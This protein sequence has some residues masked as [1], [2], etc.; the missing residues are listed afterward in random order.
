[1]PSSDTPPAVTPSA[2]HRYRKLSLKYH[3]DKDDS[4]DAAVIFAR[5]AKAYDVLS[6]S[7]LKATS[8][9]HGEQGLKHGAPDGRGGTK[10]GHYAFEVSPVSV[11][12]TFHGT[13]NPYSAL[14]DVTDAFEKLGR[15]GYASRSDGDDGQQRTFDIAVSLE[16]MHAGCVKRVSHARK[17]QRAVGGAVTEETRTLTLKIPPGCEHGRRFVFESEGDARPGVRPGPVVYVARATKHATFRRR[18][19]HLV[20][21]A[22]RSL[23]DGVCGAIVALTGIDGKRLS[24]PVEEIMDAGSTKVVR[25]EGMARRAEKGGGRGDLFLVFDL[26]FPKTL[27]PTQREMMR[28]A[29]FFPGKNPTSP[30]RRKR[31]R[32]RSC[33]PRTTVPR[34]GAREGSSRASCFA[35]RAVRDANG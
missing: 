35:K 5:V 18:G 15:T 13:T 4:A 21:A 8:D 32:R 3:S 14:I 30:R 11:F 22:R 19:D 31:R 34:G 24:I 27:S 25:G 33:S 26:V 2:P 29:F 6:N 10:G 16:E 12:E 28:A 17:T 7:A 20:Y 23:I 9:V 1:M